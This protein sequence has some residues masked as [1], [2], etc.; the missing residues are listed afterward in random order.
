MCETAA[1]TWEVLPA[2]VPVDST[3]KLDLTVDVENAR[4]SSRARENLLEL[5]QTLTG[6]LGLNI[7]RKEAIE[8]I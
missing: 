2:L 8:Q 3:A 5:K 1:G 7:C 6:L 4:L